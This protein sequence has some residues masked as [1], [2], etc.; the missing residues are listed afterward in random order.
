MSEVG[1]VLQRLLGVIE[2][3]GNHDDQSALRIGGR[4]LARDGQ[5]IRRACGLQ[6]GEE[7]DR[8]N[9]PV[10]A[11]AAKEGI[12]KSGGEWLNAD[13]IETHQ[14]HIAKRGSEPAGVF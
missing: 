12:V 13:A 9:E 4:E 2:E 10:P 14:A 1:E 6:V 5:V 7:I 3:V 11:T 8:G